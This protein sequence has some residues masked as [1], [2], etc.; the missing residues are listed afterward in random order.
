MK[1]IRQS[2]FETN[3]SSSHSLIIKNTGDEYFTEEEF[4]NNP[5]WW[6]AEIHEKWDPYCDKLH[7]GRYPFQVVSGFESKVR[8]AYANLIEYGWDEKLEEYE[9]T[10][11]EELEN[12]IKELVPGYLGIDLSKCDS[13]GTDEPYLKGWMEKYNISLREFITNKKY[14]VI[15]DG[16]EYC[17]WDMLRKAGIINFDKI[18][19]DSELEE[20]LEFERMWEEMRRN[21]NETN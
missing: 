13:I 7:F 15:C 14:I 8:Y 21:K 6:S 4:K 2:V 1:Q 5:I 11:P 12:L 19:H 16:D 9:Y 10:I 3:S 18:E 20:S 17:N